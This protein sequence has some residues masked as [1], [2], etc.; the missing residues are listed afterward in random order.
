[1]HKFRTMTGER[2]VEENLL[3]DAEWLPGPGNF[4]FVV[5]AWMNCSHYSMF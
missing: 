3:P 2:D 5:P 1:M 4:F